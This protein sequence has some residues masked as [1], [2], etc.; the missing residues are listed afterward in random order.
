MTP[1]LVC[2]GH[3]CA[4]MQLSTGHQVWSAMDMIE[5]KCSCPHDFNLDLRWTCLRSSAVVHRTPSLVCDGYVCAPMQLFTG[6]Q[7]WFA[8]NMFAPAYKIIAKPPR[9]AYDRRERAPPAAVSAARWQDIRE[10][11]RRLSMARA[12]QGKARHL[13]AAARSRSQSLRGGGHERCCA[14]GTAAGLQGRHQR[15][16]RG[17]WRSAV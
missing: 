13:P 14:R 5:F 16:T 7:V 15:S 8:M 6:H 3:V 12:L 10:L 11:H 1:S 17:A 4:P 9:F 2:D